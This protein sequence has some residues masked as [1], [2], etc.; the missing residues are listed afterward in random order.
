VL[1]SDYI[2]IKD[3]LS[4]TLPAVQ[5]FLCGDRR[6]YFSSVAKKELLVFFLK[7]LTSDLLLGIMIA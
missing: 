3:V 5:A 4:Q 7:W 2:V 6:Q 1:V